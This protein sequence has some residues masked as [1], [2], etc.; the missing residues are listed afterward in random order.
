MLLFTGTSQTLSH[1]SINTDPQG[2]IFRWITI[3]KYVNG[4][5][6][7]ILYELI[8]KHLC[9]L[10]LVGGFNPSE[11][12]ESVGMIIPNIWE[13]VPNHQPEYNSDYPN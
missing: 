6:V 13:N 1:H 11:K 3:Q 10:I 9:Q 8:S 2:T 5:A 12:Y 7:L 4:C